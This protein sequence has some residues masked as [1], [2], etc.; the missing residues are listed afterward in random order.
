[1][2]AHNAGSGL[3]VFESNGVVVHNNR[4]DSNGIEGVEVRNLDRGSTLAVHDIDIEGNT[5]AG[6]TGYAI[7]TSIGDFSGYDMPANK[8]IWVDHNVYQNP[9]SMSWIG[10]VYQGLGAVR[11]GLGFERDSPTHLQTAAAGGHGMTAT[12]VTIHQADASMKPG[13]TAADIAHV[14]GTE[15]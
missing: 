1:A 11:A 8:H 4:F 6:R 15:H 2:F 9:P 10:K 12:A 7:R 5:F 3:A 13:A 14:A